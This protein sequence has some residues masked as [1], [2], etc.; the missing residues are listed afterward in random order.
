MVRQVLGDLLDQLALQEN[1]ENRVSLDLL[2]SRGYPVPLVPLVKEVNLVIR[3]FQ[4]KLALLGPQD[5]E[6][7]VGSRER[8][9]VQDQQASKGLAG[10][11]EHLDLMER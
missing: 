9:E 4:E 6:V 1:E 10:Y 7:S 5:L 2:A 11:Q 8:E 3:V